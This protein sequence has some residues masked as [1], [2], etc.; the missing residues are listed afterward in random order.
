MGDEQI[1]DDEGAEL[2]PDEPST[3]AQDVVDEVHD[4]IDEQR[5]DAAQEAA[6][7]SPPVEGGA[8]PA[9]PPEGTTADDH[10]EDDQ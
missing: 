3:A 2:I 8:D 4:R 7:P 10:A 9:P 6:L 1:R 5:E